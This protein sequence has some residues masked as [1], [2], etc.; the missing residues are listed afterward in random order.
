[1]FTDSDPPP[2]P[3]TTMAVRSLHIMQSALIHII[4]QVTFL[5]K[6]LILS[7]QSLL[8]RMPGHILNASFLLSGFLFR[9]SHCCMPTLVTSHNG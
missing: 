8:Q 1:M 2:P 3:P 6:L 7:N 9:K 5:C 4:N